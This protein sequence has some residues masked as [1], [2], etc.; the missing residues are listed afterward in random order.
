[1]LNV[2]QNSES[3]SKLG[4]V[5]SFT[6]LLKSP[7]LIKLSYLMSYQRE[8]LIAWTFFCDCLWVDADLYVYEDFAG[9]HSIENIKSNAIVV[10]VK[11]V[12]TSFN[13]LLSNSRG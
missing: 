10:V 7:M 2:S 4:F 6:S 9:I 5:L 13:T 12:F 8:Q 1:M 3:L 11:N